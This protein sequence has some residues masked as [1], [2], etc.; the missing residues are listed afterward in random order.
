MHAFFFFGKNSI[1]LLGYY[2]LRI[3][4][5]KSLL[6][7]GHIVVIPESQKDIQGCIKTQQVEHYLRTML[8]KGRN[9]HWKIAKQFTY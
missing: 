3:L 7:Y 1:T 8:L 2:Y 5:F 9:I 4:T 6:V